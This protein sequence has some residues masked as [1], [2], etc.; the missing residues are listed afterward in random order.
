MPHFHRLSETTDGVVEIKL[1]NLYFCPWYWVQDFRAYAIRTNPRFS[2]SSWTKTKKEGW[3]FS[4][5]RR[6]FIG[7]LIISMSRISQLKIFKGNVLGYLTNLKS[8]IS[9]KG[10]RKLRYIK[11]QNVEDDYEHHVRFD[12][13]RHEIVDERVK[14]L[15]AESSVLR[16]NWFLHRLCFMS[17]RH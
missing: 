6:I 1:K 7:L 9:Y 13:A 17:V 5:I 3:A 12:L 11:L 8:V 4:K 10:D 2:S 14:P 15:L 16:H